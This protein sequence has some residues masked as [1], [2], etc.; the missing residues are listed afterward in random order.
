MANETKTPDIIIER[1]VELWCRALRVPLH[2]NGDKSEHGFMGFALVNM[3]SDAAIKEVDDYPAAIERFR[4]IL[5]AR[6]KHDRDHHGEP[7]G[8]QETWG[9]GTFR[10]ERYL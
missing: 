2:D 1:A 9:P 7:N 3:V 6:L 4:E 8:K 5:T 10:L